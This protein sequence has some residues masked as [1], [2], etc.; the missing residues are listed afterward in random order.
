MSQAFEAAV[1]FWDPE[2]HVF[3]FGDQELCLTVEEFCA[4]LGGFG[5]GEVIIPPMRES[6]YKVL[7]AALGLSGVTA[8]YLVSNGHLDVMRLIEMFSTGHASSALV[9]VAVQIEARK[10]VIPMVL[11]ETLMGLDKICSGET[12][13][14]RGSPLLLQ[15]E[16]DVRQEVPAEVLVDVVLPLFRHSVLCNYQRFWRAR[17]VTDAH[18]YPSVAVRGN[19]WKWLRRD[20]AARAGGQ[21]N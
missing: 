11:A 12:E 4:F 17:E 10:D 19:Y 9:S 18:P 1:S 14:F 15:C 5:S 2:V 6:I 7:A 20:I 21:G 3:C 13:T 8:R 16:L